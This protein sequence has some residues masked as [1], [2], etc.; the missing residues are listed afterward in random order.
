MSL[1][2]MSSLKGSRGLQTTDRY[3]GMGGKDV[4]IY[5][6]TLHTILNSLRS[7]PQQD[8]SHSLIVLQSVLAT[9]QHVSSKSEQLLSSPQRQPD[10]VYNNVCRTSHRMTNLLA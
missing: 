8:F 1:L 7:R 4:D 6:E 2:I 9:Y 10:Q 3:T 5:L